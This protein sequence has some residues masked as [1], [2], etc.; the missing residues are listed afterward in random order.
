M[1]EEYEHVLIQ[2]NIGEMHEAYFAN[3]KCHIVG[4][5]A[6]DLNTIKAWRPRPEEYREVLH[7]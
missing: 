4:M 1:P 2:T 3:G 7:D 5:T 6:V